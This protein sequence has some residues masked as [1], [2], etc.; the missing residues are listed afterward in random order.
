M[1]LSPR[2]LRPNDR[3]AIVAPASPIMTDE[4]MHG[5]DI[6]REVGLEPVLG[7]CVKNLRAINDHSASVPERVEELNWAFTDPKIKGVIGAVGGVGSAALLPYLDYEKIRASRKPFVGM[8]DLTSINCALLSC[9]GLISFN[10]QT[11]SIRLDK[12]QQIQES[13]SLS[14][15]VTLQLLMS[16]DTWGTRPFDFNPYFPRT[17]CPGK[18]FGPAIGGNCD[19][20]V[21][22]Y[23]TQYMPDLEDAVLFIEDVHKGGESMIRHFMQLRLAG[24]LRRVSAVVI[25]EFAE[26]PKNVD[27]KIPSV[28]EAVIEFF[29]SGPPC[30]YGYPFSHGPLTAPIPVGAPC[31]VNADTGEVY[32]DFRMST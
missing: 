24:D 1:Y 11:P 8:S 22:L 20:M 18:G 32:F 16:G 31:T 3:I 2:R 28:E 13:D 27:P 17:V 5:M 14:L 10:G 12:G 26:V 4:V 7:P 9:A 15:Q 6:I 21:H 29:S 30:A 19:T 23:G 25:G